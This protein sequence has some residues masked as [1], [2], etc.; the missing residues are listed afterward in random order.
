M[1]NVMKALPWAIAFVV[2]LGIYLFVRSSRLKG[3][4]K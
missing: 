3:K 4:A 2:V 1:D